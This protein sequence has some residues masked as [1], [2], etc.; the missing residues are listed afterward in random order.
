[1]A[2]S[3]FGFPTS[4]PGSGFDDAIDCPQD[5][6]EVGEEDEYDALN[7]E[8]FGEDATDGDW[9]QDHEKLAQ[10]TESTRPLVQTTAST[11]N[12]L[13]VDIEGSLS[14]LVLD[15]KDGI[16]PRPGV[17]DSPT[18]VLH[19]QPQPQIHPGSQQP[20]P[21]ALKFVQTVEEL[22]RGL[23]RPPP[24]LAKPPPTITNAQAPRNQFILDYSGLND[25]LPVNLC[26]KIFNGPLRPRFPPGLA[27]P[28]PHPVVLPPNVHL[29]NQLLQNPRPMPP[30]QTNLILGRHSMPR[31]LIVNQRQTMHGNFVGNFPQPRLNL[32]QF[33]RPDQPV[34]RFAIP[35]NHPNQHNNQRN[36]C[37]SHGNEPPAANHQPF[38]KNNQ[39]WHQNRNNQRYNHHRH[40]NQLNGLN[41]NGE[42]DEYSGLMSSREKQWLTNI[43]LL[44]HKTN[45]PYVDDYY[46]T[47]FSER[48]NKK[49]DNQDSRDRK[50]NNN[51]F[52]RDPRDKEQHVL[53]KVV[54]TPTQFENS[55]GKLQCGSVTAPRKI[56]D[57]DVVPNSD[58]QQ[59]P[60]QKDMKKA[61]QRL[62]EIERLY[63]VQLKLE[64]LSNPLA[65]VAEPL[66]QPQ[67]NEE[68]KAPKKTAP[69]LINIMLTSLI[70]LL[71]EDKLASILS[72]RKGKNLLLRFLP[73]L[74]V[75]E[76]GAQLGELWTGLLRGLAIVG[77]RDAY[78]L[79]KFFPEFHRWIETTRD[80]ETVLR[81]ARGF[82][83]SVNQNS[84]INNS[85]AFAVTNK[86]G[87]SVIASLLEQAENLYPDDKA[88]TQEWS[89]FIV[90]LSEAVGASTPSV[91]PCHPVA[92]NTLHQHLKRIGS[93]K[94]E[95]YEPL[96]S[97][98]TD[99]N[100]SR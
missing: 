73:F 32:P 96:E 37:R 30:N 85:L 5:D 58:P 21:V 38:F 41:D 53:T 71:H 77:R 90:S 39:Y 52:G 15:E 95:R 14:H 8:T 11:K 97:L 82:L 36:Q 12:G 1:M 66:E 22:E 23:I 40:H 88:M 62:L 25:H 68:P 24:G 6:D 100:P 29:P 81:L 99:A 72:I 48:Q 13:D 18:L 17:W 34:P 31:H 79:V 47:V 4:H 75:T 44:Q 65:Q 9:E 57:M 43:Q 63:T 33:I 70:Q 7:D 42:Y 78:L 55:L 84:R 54:Y 50:Q 3:F 80:F 86:F 46:F 67:E 94:T 64:D 87:V 91:A 49:N 61:R 16:V 92:A 27:L 74:S 59:H 28:G 26:Q 98:L 60:Q 35:T 10:I 56:I 69:E 19:P 83:D 2:D 20:L 51:G 93:L 45:Q 89:T 76:Y